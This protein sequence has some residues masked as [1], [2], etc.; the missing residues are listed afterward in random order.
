MDTLPESPLEKQLADVLLPLLNLTQLSVHDNFFALGG[1]SFIATRFTSELRRRHNI[2]LPLWQ[3][4]NLQ[5]IAR[6]AQ[7]LQSTPAEEAE[8]IF[9]EGSL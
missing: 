5:T 3:V 9:E 4:F 1:D 8:M 7:Q 6:M 2:D